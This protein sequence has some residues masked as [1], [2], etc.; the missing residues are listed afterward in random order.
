[1]GCAR[2][3]ADPVAAAC[4]VDQTASV[5][6]QRAWSPAGRHRTRHRQV[7]R[8]R[9]LRSLRSGHAEAG[10]RLGRVGRQSVALPEREVYEHTLVCG[11]PGSGKSSG[12]FIPNILSERGTRSLVIV[13]PKSELLS[14][15]V[16]A[17]SRH[18]EIW[19]VNFLDPSMSHGYNPLAL[20]NSYLSAEAFAE[21]WVSNTGRS[22]HEPFWDNATKL[23]IVAAV[24]H[25]RA[26]HRGL[27][28]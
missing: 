4:T 8:P 9:D 7:R 27:P 23:L 1:M 5:A 18:S 22:A 13:D 6:H 26:E 15:T 10:L 12:L 2:A 20:V 24:L 11:P 16:D 14:L 19:V 17:V 25:L 21:C 28:R 3:L